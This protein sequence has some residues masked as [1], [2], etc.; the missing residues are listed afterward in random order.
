M[1]WKLLDLLS[2]PKV[3]DMIQSKNVETGESGQSLTVL[4]MSMMPPMVQPRHLGMGHG[5]QVLHNTDSLIESDFGDLA[6]ELLVSGPENEN[7]TM[8]ITHQECNAVLSGPYLD[9]DGNL[10]WIE[11]HE[12]PKIHWLVQ[13]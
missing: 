13:G 6:F 4:K 10:D 2:Q 8:I 11:I 9:S 3:G 1:S 7:Y 5:V 12:I